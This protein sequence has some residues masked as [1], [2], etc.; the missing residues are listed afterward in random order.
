MLTTS[1]I[2]PFWDSTAPRETSPWI[3]ARVAASPLSKPT[4]PR[5]LQTGRANFN[6]VGGSISSS[7]NT[8]R[9]VVPVDFPSQLLIF[10]RL[11]HGI[12]CPQLRLLRLRR[13]QPMLNSLSTRDGSLDQRSATSQGGWRK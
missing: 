11:L 13:V 7:T 3:T 9:R 12:I 10:S 1:L 2:T 8:L 4:L 6:S 5:T